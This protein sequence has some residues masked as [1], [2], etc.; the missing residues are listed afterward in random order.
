[1]ATLLCPIQLRTFGAKH[2]AKWDLRH[3]LDLKISFPR[4]ENPIKQP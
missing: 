4:N 1:M 2:T 3:I